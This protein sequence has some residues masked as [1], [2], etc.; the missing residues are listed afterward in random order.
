MEAH[1]LEPHRA[2][3][4]RKRRRAGMVGDL[5]LAVEDVE[6]LLDVG[7]GLLDLAVDHAHEVERLVEL[8]QHGVDHDEV[9]HRVDARGN[10]LHDHDHAGRQTDG[11]DYGL[12]CVEDGQRRVGLHARRLEALHRAVVALRLAALGPEILHRLV[13]EQAVDGLGVGV[14]IALVHPA[15][16]ADAPLGRLGGEP[17]VGDDH[18]DRDGGVAPVEL[19]QQHAEDH[20]ELDDSRETP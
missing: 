18:D 9:A 13:V 14:G 20:H 19:P 7:S 17:H 5:G 10:A 3:A 16:D 6:H 12:A 15:A 1:V 8:D 4:D 2:G 11:E